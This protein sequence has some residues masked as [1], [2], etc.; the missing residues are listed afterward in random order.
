MMTELKEKVLATANFLTERGLHLVTAESCTGGG[1]SYWLTSVPGSSHWFDRGFVTYS[2]AAKVA[3]LGL[4]P[5]ALE[6]NGAVSE[7]TA[8]AMAKGALLHS[9]ADCAIAITGIAGPEGGSADKP[10]GT[11][12]IAWADHH[13]AKAQV[14]HLDGDRQAVRLQS[15]LAALKILNDSL[16][17]GNGEKGRG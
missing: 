8:L 14:F 5:Q 6:T 4:D 2:N 9:R 11:V 13:D 16:L 3:M 15:M 7:E 17:P 10:V 1:L 12:W